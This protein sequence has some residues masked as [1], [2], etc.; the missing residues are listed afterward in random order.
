MI[1]ILMTIAGAALYRWRGHASKYKKFFPRPLN[2]I[3]F[4]APYAYAVYLMGYDWYWY[5][6]VL[7]LSTLGVLTGHGKFMD[8]ASYK[9]LTSDETL[10]FLIKQW[11]DKMS[12]Y[13]Y[14]FLGLAVTGVAVTLAAGTLLGNPLLAF[15]GA[16]KAPAYA[17]A[18]KL[19]WGTAGGEWLTG[20]FLWGS[21]ALLAY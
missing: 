11:E 20:A 6:P 9:I 14:D 8:L 16:L 2:Q 7:V 5:I 13:W 21:L 4:A 10:E 19:G 3:A 1:Y 15:S 18:K 12:N 17:I